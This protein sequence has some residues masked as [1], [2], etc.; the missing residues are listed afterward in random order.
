MSLA[1]TPCLLQACPT[2]DAPFS[3]FGR[4][5]TA[6]PTE[7]AKQKIRETVIGLQLTKRPLRIF[8]TYDLESLRFRFA[9]PLSTV[10]VSS[11]AAQSTYL[12]NRFMSA[13][14]QKQRNRRTARN[15]RE[16]LEAD[17]LV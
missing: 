9:W 5:L 12:L 14:L 3:V 13:S 16:G 11:K 8:T 4:P 1:V 17:I 6:Y 10:R 7:I 2:V 15:C